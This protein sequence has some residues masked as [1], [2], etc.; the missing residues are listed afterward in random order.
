MSSF[1]REIAENTAA[2]I[3]AVE[4]IPNLTLGD[5]NVDTTGLAQEL[6]LG[7]VKDAL[8]GS[9]TSVGESLDSIAGD[10]AQLYQDSVA[11]RA[12]WETDGFASQGG[13]GLAELVDGVRANTNNLDSGLAAILEEL[14]GT[15]GQNYLASDATLGDIADSVMPGGTVAEELGGIHYDTTNMGTQLGMMLQGGLFFSPSQPASDAFGRLRVSQPSSVFDAKS[16]VDN[17]PLAF[18]DQAVSGSGTGSAHSA[19]TASVVLSVSLNTAGK[20][21]RQSKR[22]LAYQP[23]KSQLA[24]ITFTMG[25]KAAGITRE[26]GLYDDNNGIF[27]QQTNAALKWIVRSKA[28]GSVVDDN[29]AAQAN[30]SED[31]LDGSAD[32]NNPSGL[33]LDM[34]DAQ[35]AIIDYE[36]LG[37][38]TVRVGFVID[39]AIIYVHHFHH[40]NGA[41]GVYM[42]TPN[43]PV[44]WS[45]AN[46]GTGAAKTLEAICA[47]V[48]S[49]GGQDRTGLT[50]TIDRAATG[51]TTLN[52]NALYPLIAIR[53]KSGALGATIRAVNMSVFCTTSSIFRWALL[54]NPTVTGT[55]FSFSDVTNSSIQADVARDS[56]TKVT[57][58]TLLASGYS[59]STTQNN[60][61]SSGSNDYALGSLIDGT[62]DI[63]VLAVQRL[64]GTTETF[65]GTLGYSDQV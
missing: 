36:W 8:F 39:G 25:D 48:I 44:R 24:F 20:R 51:L 58:G 30:W 47:S 64:T 15:G 61:P 1:L 32:A 11:M 53:L 12:M 57:N 7:L 10:T 6:T 9:G 16:I 41:A 37:V 56:N 43:L 28:T 21:V 14:N 3:T 45:I 2:T 13:D 5:V 33:L 50:L 55:A 4:A 19:N 46:D 62:S 60:V 40:A 38:G 49:E 27:L 63:L 52:D 31:T 59:E 23:G 22:R 26:V 18:D 54:L 65:Y 35:I 42:S 34:A 29:F 17:Q